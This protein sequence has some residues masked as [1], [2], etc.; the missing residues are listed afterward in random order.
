M[1]TKPDYLPME[2]LAR[3]GEIIRVLGH[4][5]RLGIVDVLDL[6]G[7]LSA[8]RISELRGLSQSQTSQHLSQM[9]RLGVVTARREGTQ[10][11]YRLDSIQPRTIIG[12]LRAHYAEL[13]KG[14]T[15]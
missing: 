6:E 1:K 2:F 7:E 5:Q 12:C 4:P 15:S 3:V 13:N 8:G 9:R 10:V 11:F 14:A